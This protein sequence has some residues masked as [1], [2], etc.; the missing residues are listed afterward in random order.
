MDYA[1][2][3]PVK[4]WGRARVVADDSQ[5]LARLMPEG[6]AARPEQAI[7]F[8]IETWDVN[9]TQHIPQ[10]LDAADVAATVEKL[11]HHIVALEAEN[12]RLRTS[13]GPSATRTDE[14][15]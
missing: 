4:I 12:A 9:C 13:L 7:L 14:K 6:Y 2:R 5:L 15:P 11:E 10:K 3:R 1:E 8:T